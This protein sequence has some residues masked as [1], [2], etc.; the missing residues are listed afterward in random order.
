M[1]QEPAARR[2][3]ALVVDRDAGGQQREQAVARRR[4]VAAVK[5]ALR[6]GEHAPLLASR[7]IGEK[8]KPPSKRDAVTTAA[9]R[10]QR[11]RVRPRSR[12]DGAASAAGTRA[13]ARRAAASVGPAS[14]ERLEHAPRVGEVHVPGRPRAA[15]PPKPQPPKAGDDF[16]EAVRADRTGPRRA[17]PRIFCTSAPVRGRAERGPGSAGRRRSSSSGYSRTS[18]SATPSR[19]SPFTCRRRN[20]R[21]RR[22]AVPGRRAGRARRADERVQHERRQRLP[23]AEQAV[24]LAVPAAVLRPAA[25]RGRRTP[26]AAD[27][28][29]AAVAR[30]SPVSG[31]REHDGQRGTLS[32]AARRAWPCRSTAASR[33]AVSV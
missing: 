33:S 14:R 32:A 15:R 1:A 11:R 18:G 25:T 26:A 9:R 22:H 30:R 8:K 6:I 17:A 29:G 24:R 31:D 16:R 20:A 27:A 4:R 13:P 2:A 10:L 12:R 23:G 19:P 7:T 28:A 21:A 5:R 3:H